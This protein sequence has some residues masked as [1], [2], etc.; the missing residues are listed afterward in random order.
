MTIRPAGICTHRTTPKPRWQ[1]VTVLLLLL[2]LLGGSAPANGQESGP[3]SAPK[4]LDVILLIDSSPSTRE[5]DRSGWRISASRFLLDYL[6][7]T[8]Q[9]LRV[10]YR[11]GVANFGG[12]MGATT[13]LR[14]LE[15]GIVQGT[16][17]SETVS[18]TDFRPPLDWA[19]REFRAR[20]FGVGNA[21]AIILF[22]DGNPQLTDQRLA[23][24]QKAQYFTGQPLAGDASELRLPG[25]VKE[26]QDAGITVLTVGIGDARQDA[27]FWQNLVGADNYRSLD[28]AANLP[29]IYHEFA[30]RLLGAVASPARFLQAADSPAR[31]TVPPYLEQVI[32]SFVKEKPAVQV[33]LTDPTGKTYSPTAG[34]QANDLHQIYAIANPAPGAWQITVSGGS[35]QLWVD[36]RLSRLLIEGP[37]GPQILRQPLPLTARLVRNGEAITDQAL[38]IRI[39]VALPGAGGAI[40]EAMART[41]GGAF[42]FTLVPTLSGVYTVTATSRL[43]DQLL[44]VDSVPLVLAAYPAPSVGRFQ[45]DGAIAPGQTVILRARLNDWD[46]LARD[47]AVE[48]LLFDQAEMSLGTVS[49][50]DDGR[51]PDQQAGDGVYSADLIIAPSLQA[52]E[53][54]IAGRT[55]NGVSF[56]L[57]ER[58]SLAQ[59]MITTT[60]ATVVATPTLDTHTPAVSSATPTTPT[61]DRTPTPT[62]GNKSGI[63]GG[64]WGW[65]A[66]ALAAGAAVVGGVLLWG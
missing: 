5:T 45:V 54:A 4:P 1:W 34:G 3:L 11:A 16:I 33:T 9:V 38:Q 43:N 7:A 64:D 44:A 46:R 15:G 32:F 20:S 48:A 8:S 55:V 17:V 30:V 66:L 52:V 13:P 40:E 35:T 25:L 24:E 42:V 62:P 22:T 59:A 61:A 37:Q 27:S 36:Q 47:Q 18:Y 6:Q 2:S 31:E 60:P 12:R 63:E 19:L 51:A 57:R 41:D 65:L 58:Y 56:S 28:D 39:S 14:L 29:T 21:M 50:H 53:L 10:N 23:A 26:L 49:L